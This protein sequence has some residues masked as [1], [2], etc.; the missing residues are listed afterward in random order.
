MKSCKL[1]NIGEEARNMAQAG[2]KNSS[3]RFKTLTM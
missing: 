3:S 2:T 1:P